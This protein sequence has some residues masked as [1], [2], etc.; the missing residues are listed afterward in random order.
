MTHTHRKT[1]KIKTKK[2][3]RPL[4]KIIF[5]DMMYSIT[6]YAKSNFQ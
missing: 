6:T 4:Q 2:T 1:A 3:L 5:E